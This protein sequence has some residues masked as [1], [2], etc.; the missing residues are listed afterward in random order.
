[1]YTTLIMQRHDLIIH[2]RRLERKARQ[3]NTTERQSNTTQLAQGS[4]YSKKKLGWDSNTTTICLLGVALTNWA[5]EAA[6][7]AGFES[8]HHK[9]DKHRWTQTGYKEKAAVIKPAKTPNTKPSIYMYMTSWSVWD[10][11]KERQGNTHNRNTKQQNTTRPRQ[12]PWVGFK[13]TTFH[14]LGVTLT[15]WVTKAA[16]LAGLESHIRTIQSN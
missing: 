9:P 6:Q 11:W 10:A 8:K 16:Q 4:Y 13:P 15:N 3:H 1:M 14:L 2:M 7:L 5:T 12:L